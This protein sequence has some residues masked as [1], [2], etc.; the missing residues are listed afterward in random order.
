MFDRKKLFDLLVTQQLEYSQLAVKIRNIAS[1]SR[2]NRKKCAR[3]IIKNEHS[4]ADLPDHN[5]HGKIIKFSDI[6]HIYPI[7]IVNFILAEF[8]YVIRLKLEKIES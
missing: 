1:E 7:D 3:Q 4:L 2:R 5:L 8:G 6:L